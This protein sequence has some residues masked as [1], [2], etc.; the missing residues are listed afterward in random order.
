MKTF[1]VTLHRAVDTYLA[2]RSPMIWV[3][4]THYATL[5]G[6][7]IFLLAL[8]LGSRVPYTSYSYREE[9]D[10]W[11]CTY[12]DFW[13]N[14]WHLEETGGVFEYAPFYPYLSTLND[15]PPAPPVG[16]QGYY[17]EEREFLQKYREIRKQNIWDQYPGMQSN[18]WRTYPSQWSVLLDGKHILLRRLTKYAPD[19]W[20]FISDGDPGLRAELGN[21]LSARY[22]DMWREF[23]DYRASQGA[24]IADIRISLNGYIARYCNS[25]PFASLFL[26]LFVIVIILGFG[27]MRWQLKV[28]EL[29]SYQKPSVTT[30]FFAYTVG[31]GALGI[32]PFGLIVSFSRLDIPGS[33]FAGDPYRIFDFVSIV[34][35]AVILAALF[36]CVRK[37]VSSGY[38]VIGLVSVGCV[39]LFAV[40]APT[41][42]HAWQLDWGY[43]DVI[44][45]VVLALFIASAAFVAVR[46]RRR[47]SRIYEE[48]VGVVLGALPF[49]PRMIDLL[50]RGGLPYEDRLVPYFFAGFVSVTFSA[51]V[52]GSILRTVRA[53]PGF[54]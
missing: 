16:N 21:L 20:R 37:S 49:L 44:A 38:S 25:L 42:K 53:S 41:W 33:F 43:L 2:T 28:R 8:F 5:L 39:C 17:P 18:L 9:G 31:L 7:I 54:P 34:G 1:I 10:L 45:V 35:F 4:K 22:M 50:S 13:E 47:R 6:C 26:F 15:M 14:I 24:S 29:P 46:A 3:T 11:T 48:C 40:A 52:W 12:A 23:P 19:F 30:W 27:W 51:A 36:L 32:G